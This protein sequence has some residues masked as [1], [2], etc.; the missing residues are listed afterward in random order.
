METREE[1]FNILKPIF[2]GFQDE[3]DTKFYKDSD[4]ALSFAQYSEEQEVYETKDL[5][6]VLMVVIMEAMKKAEL[7]KSI[8]VYVCGDN[9]TLHI[10]EIENWDDLGFQDH[11]SFCDKQ[12]IQSNW[13]LYIGWD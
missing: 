3:E 13:D 9:A 7:C 5:D 12:D 10:E 11:L 6:Q 4:G 2:M 8:Y 1:I